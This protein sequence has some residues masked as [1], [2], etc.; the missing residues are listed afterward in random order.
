MTGPDGLTFAGIV[1]SGNSY[2]E[3]GHAGIQVNFSGQWS[4][5]WHATGW[6]LQT[7]TAGSPP[8]YTAELHTSPTKP[9]FKVLHSFTG[10]VDGAQS[11]AGLTMDK[12]GN[13]YGTTAYGGTGGGPYSDVLPLH[14]CG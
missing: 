3:L 5:G 1:E 14:G 9:A 13:L 7:Y 10:G 11:N 4:N 6:I 12:A 8:I 2:H